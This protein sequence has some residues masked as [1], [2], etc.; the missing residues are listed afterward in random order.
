MQSQDIA[1]LWQ[2]KPIINQFHQMALFQADCLLWAGVDFFDEGRFCNQ[3]LCN[4]L[5]ISRIYSL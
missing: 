4:Q 3:L 5:A 1:L 2:F